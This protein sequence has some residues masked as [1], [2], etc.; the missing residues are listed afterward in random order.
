[1][2]STNREGECVTIF[3]STNGLAIQIE[4]VER[5]W[6]ADSPDGEREVQRR[7]WTW[8]V[9]DMRSPQQLIPAL[10]WREAD[11]IFADLG[12]TK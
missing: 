10:N 7:S 6:M 8:W 5:W 9:R 3:R 2:D 1:M 12:G 4:K 11:R